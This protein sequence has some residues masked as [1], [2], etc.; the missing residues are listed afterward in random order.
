MLAWTVVKKLWRLRNELVLSAECRSC[1]KECRS[2]PRQVLA[3][4]R[5]RGISTENNRGFCHPHRNPIARA[6]TP[7]RDYDILKIPQWRRRRR[8]CYFL[9]SC[10]QDWR[11]QAEHMGASPQKDP[12]SFAHLSS[13]VGAP[14]WGGEVG[15]PR[16]AAPLPADRAGERGRAGV[17]PVWFSA[18]S[19]AESLRNGVRTVAL[20]RC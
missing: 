17:K 13:G 14:G 1:P 6:A 18:T 5:L 8:R 9:P 11:R 10:A 20:S 7:Q 12:C 2:C 4:R 3:P 15:V 16:R 19:F